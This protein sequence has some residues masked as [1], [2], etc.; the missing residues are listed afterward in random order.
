MNLDELIGK[1]LE[2]TGYLNNDR[3]SAIVVYGS[4]VRGTNKTTSDLDIL[5]I[6][7]NRR[8]IKAAMIIDGIK[9]DYNIFSSYD[10]FE[11]A[12][13]KRMANNA[14]FESIL[15]SGRVIKNNGILE[16]FEAYLDELSD[17]KIH[18]RK[19]SSKVLEEIKN[20]YENFTSSKSS[21]WYFNLL[22][23]LRMTYNYLKNCSY[24]SM[25]K[26]Y[27]VFSNSEFYEDAYSIKLPSS[28]FISLF[29]D[30][31][32]VKNFEI[33]LKIVN[34]I[35]FNLGIDIYKEVD[36]IEDSA[37][38]FYENDIK[39]ELLVIYNKVEKVIDFLSN[40]H[41][42]ADYAYNV[43]L[44]QIELFYQRVYRSISKEIS[45]AL[46]SANNISNGERIRTL[47]GLFG[48]V[49]KDYRFDYD[50]YMLKLNL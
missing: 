32:N 26:V 36:Y 39:S 18:K 29:L 42:Y 7:E 16:E 44:R 22:E 31:V 3:I 14:Y 12:Y 38:F 13:E 19:L 33:Q 11:I 48:I 47:K 20:L 35:M 15:K 6:T 9:V 45:D 23:K 25:V 24:V 17:M 50:N 41:P 40:N 30:G 21:Y 43:L 4:R 5:V 1:F 2:R 28:D 27:E 8:N 46:K 10:L 49:D 37:E 34:K